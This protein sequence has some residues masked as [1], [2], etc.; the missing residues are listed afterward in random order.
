MSRKL[1]KFAVLFI[2]GPILSIPALTADKMPQAIVTGEI[3]LSSGAQSRDSRQD[4]VPNATQ[5]QQHRY[6]GTQRGRGCL[7]QMGKIRG[8]YRSPGC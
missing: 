2:L 8:D 6:S 4:D 7:P 3:C 5:H 1:R